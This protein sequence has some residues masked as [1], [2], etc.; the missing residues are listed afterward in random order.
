MRRLGIALLAA[1][2]LAAAGCSRKAPEPAP[3]ENVEE[4]APAAPEPA[5]PPPPRVEPTK[6]KPSVVNEAD[7]EPAPDV[8]AQTQEDAD[9]VGM[10]TRAPPSE[11]EDE[12]GPATNMAVSDSAQ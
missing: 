12:A 11:S 5:P 9:A 8:S 1:F 4:V 3:E 6:E 10:T 2:A 7:D